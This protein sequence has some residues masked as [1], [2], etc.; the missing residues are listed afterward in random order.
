M[1]VY[2][3]SKEKALKF[4]QIIIAFRIHFIS[5][6]TQLNLCTNNR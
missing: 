6:R 5:F 2:K 3:N 1:I 4:R